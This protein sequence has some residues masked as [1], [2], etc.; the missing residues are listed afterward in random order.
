MYICV[1]KAVSDKRIDRSVQAG[2]V[3]LRELSQQTGLGTCCGKCV[4]EARR[5]LSES[6]A[7]HGHRNAMPVAA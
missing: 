4:G 3:T 6:L 1:C 7:R 5:Q 2:V